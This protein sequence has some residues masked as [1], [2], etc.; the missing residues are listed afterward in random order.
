MT[1]ADFLTL[2]I[3][4]DQLMFLGSCLF[5]EF[6]NK[7]RAQLKASGQPIY[8]ITNYPLFC[9]S[10]SRLAA[11]SVQTGQ[12]WRP[13]EIISHSLTSTSAE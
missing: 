4:Y 7:K 1:I 12:T 10:F 13:I 6:S 5:N 8:L 2:T 11:G 9:P 3:D